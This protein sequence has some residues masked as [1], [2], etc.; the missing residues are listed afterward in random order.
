MNEI[1]I[2]AKCTPEYGEI[3]PRIKSG[4]KNI[5]IQLIN[6]MLTKHNYI[7]TKRVI[8]QDNIDI[9]VVHTPLVK[10]EGMT[11]EIAL[12]FLLLPEYPEML[13]DTCKYAEYI[14]ETEDKRIKVVVHNNYSKATWI[15]TNLIKEKIGPILNNILQKYEN[16][17]LVIENS[18]A[19]D[20][21]RFKTVFD[22]EDV[23]YVVNEINK[24]IGNRAK[25][26]LD[27]CHMMMSC[28][29]WKRISGKD[30]LD[31]NKIFKDATMYTDL[32]L[33]HLNNIWDNGFKED[34]GRP[35][36][37]EHEGD[38]E[39]LKSI[40]NA[41]E[42]YTNCE[43]SI[44]VVEEDYFSAPKNLIMTK[45]QLEKLGYSLNI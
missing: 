26:L 41:Y 14:A 8:E 44:E 40:M 24:I 28:E 29:A 10:M 19:T 33:I 22:M 38:M 23:S 7:D 12:N 32:G 39:K 17:D 3:L 2:N 20:N 34:H 4:F 9:S 35:F 30:L 6:R 5:E 11:D 36:S 31:W 1:R 13:E 37:P 25:T 45:E 21:K 27:T 15:E 43:I 16:V 18:C 42:K